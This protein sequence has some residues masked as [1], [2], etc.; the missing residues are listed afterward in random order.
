MQLF[1]SFPWMRRSALQLAV[2]SVA[3]VIIVSLAACGGGPSS[4]TGVTSSGP[5][6]LTIWSWVPN[7]LE[8]SAALF[9]QT[10]PNIHVTVRNVGAGPLEY[11]KLFTAIKANNEPDMALMEYQYMP[12]FEA[13]GALVDLAPYGANSVKD[14]FVPWTWSLSTLGSAV[15]MIPWDSGPMIM[16]YRADLFKKYNIP[17]PTTWAQYADD[18]AKLHAADP[19]AYMTDF[20]PRQPGEFIGFAWQAGAR[21]FG[22]N[23]QSWQVSIN[24]PQA[25]QV[26]AYWQGLIDKKLIKTEPD[27]ANA[28]INDMQT[29]VF[30]TW[31]SGPWGLGALETLVPKSSGAWRVAPLPQWQAGQS[32]DGVW[33]GGGNVVFKSSKHPKEA[34]EFVQWVASNQQ[35][36]DN[37]IKASTLYPAD[38]AGLDNPFWS[39]PLPFIGNQVVGPVLKQESAEV[40]INFQWG[41]T[42]SQVYN[43]IGDNFANVVNGQGTLMDAL[44]AVQQ[45]TVTYMKKQGFSVSTS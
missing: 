10:H 21:L 25:L 43:D 37:V 17:V 3:L 6:N 39:T 22:I 29:G 34:A 35:S 1:S 41:P 16:T 38:Q 18:A 8:K 12:T 44:N 24:S 9:T 45:S 28:W 42:T 15:Y 14:Q 2:I 4:G 26:A 31:F 5:V 19:N 23:G 33:G 27:F 40:D 13:T 7:G 32:V 30:A 11:N 36:L 20:P